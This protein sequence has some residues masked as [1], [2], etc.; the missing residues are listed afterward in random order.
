MAATSILLIDP[1]KRYLR[2][3]IDSLDHRGVS[4]TT[5]DSHCPLD[6]AE[7]VDTIVAPWVP[8]DAQGLLDLI[9]LKHAL[10]ARVLTI[11]ASGLDLAHIEEAYGLGIDE[12]IA[13]PATPQSLLVTLLRPGHRG[14]RNGPAFR[15]VCCPT[16]A[17][18]LCQMLRSARPTGK[19]K[20]LLTR[21]AG[22]LRES[23]SRSRQGGGRGGSG[24][25]SPQLDVHL[26]GR[27]RVGIAG[28][29]V[30]RWP[31]RKAKLLFAYLLH[32][33]KRPSNRETLMELFWPGALP[34]S[35][36]N[37]LNVAMHAVRRIL[38]EVDPLHA[39][40]RY[41]TEAYAI[42]S[43]VVVHLDTEEVS[44]CWADAQVRARTSPPREI[45][46]LLQRALSSYNGDFLED[47]LYD[48]WAG[49]ERE[50]YRE[51]CMS[52]MDR[53]S[54]LLCEDRQ[55]ESAADLCG[56]LLAMDPCQEE[57]HRRLMLCYSSLG[58]R[59]R[60]MRQFAVCC[61]I[62]RKELAADPS[63]ATRSF[64]ESIARGTP[65]LRIKR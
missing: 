41:D 13:A 18:A 39:Y 22:R 5:W 45:I 16:T 58:H 63:P 8:G 19:G 14:P 20:G 23:T 59:S 17:G 12:L 30:A 9:A 27:F 36:R 15:V 48:E 2:P 61:D 33:H 42:D 11:I 4:T 26:L 53:L 3:F 7:P 65:S 21:V 28:Q 35:S 47:E 10:H 55:W 6:P 60:A 34:D 29:E 24:G 40:V 38:H 25:T 46:R 31:N 44:R 51:V 49:R 1:E 52:V 54:C 50:H 62:L 32:N 64:F 56:T 37:S 43:S 57:V